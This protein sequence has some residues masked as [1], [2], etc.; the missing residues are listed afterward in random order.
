MFNNSILLLDIHSPIND[1]AVRLRKNAVINEP[2]RFKEIV[3]FIINRIII[4]LTIIIFMIIILLLI[5]VLTIH[6]FSFKRT[7]NIRLRL[8]CS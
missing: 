1:L 7:S 3:I 5:I 8:G 4:N 2:I 6:G